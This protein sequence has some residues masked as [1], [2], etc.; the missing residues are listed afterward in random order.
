MDSL[1][2]AMVHSKMGLLVKERG[3]IRVEM[4]HLKTVPLVKQKYLVL[5]VVM[6][7]VLPTQISLPVKEK[8]LA[9]AVSENIQTILFV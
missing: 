2:V 4:V 3:R 9:P 6:E 8:S 5:A 7:D 1:L